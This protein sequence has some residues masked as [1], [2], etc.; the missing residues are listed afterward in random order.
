MTPTLTLNKFN[1]VSKANIICSNSKHL[2]KIMADK[3]WRD[4][5]SNAETFWVEAPNI[6]DRIATYMLESSKKKRMMRIK[7]PV[8]LLMQEIILI[9]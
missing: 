3:G 6:K 7:I 9:S 4:L 1:V 8:S 2:M 5:N